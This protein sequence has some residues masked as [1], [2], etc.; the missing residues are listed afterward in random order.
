M[1]KLAFPTSDRNM[2]NCEILGVKAGDMGR[3][4]R[5]EKRRTENDTDKMSTSSNTWPIFIFDI[6]V[7]E[8]PKVVG[9]CRPTPMQGSY[10]GVGLAFLDEMKKIRMLTRA[11]TPPLARHIPRLEQP[12]N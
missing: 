2:N 9:H 10:K 11:T 8:L 5:K 1:P 4:W 3:E 7:E 6:Q 12:M